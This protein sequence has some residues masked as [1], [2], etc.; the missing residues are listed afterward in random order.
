MK[1]SEAIKILSTLDP[2]SVLK[3]RRTDDEVGN[4]L[5][6]PESGITWIFEK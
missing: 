4:I 6:D 5:S 1:I 2:D 3:I